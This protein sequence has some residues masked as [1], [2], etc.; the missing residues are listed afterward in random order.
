MNTLEHIVKFFIYKSII[1]VTL[2][3]SVL[4]MNSVFA[5][6]ELPATTDAPVEVVATVAPATTSPE[7]TNAALEVLKER[8]EQIKETFE[9]SDIEKEEAVAQSDL[10][11]VQLEKKTLE[12]INSE[13][14]TEVLQLQQQIAE[15]ESLKT[16]L[17]LAEQKNSES[18][19]KVAEL[20]NAQKEL[21]KELEIRNLLLTKNQEDID[22]L[23]QE[24]ALKEYALEQ[25]LELQ[26][27]LQEKTKEENSK[28]VWIFLMTT[29]FFLIIYIIRIVVAKKIS[30][31]KLT[32][33]K[34]AHKFA[35]FD[36]ISFLGY[37]GFLVWFL[38]YLKPEMVVYL[39]FLVG[40]IVIVVQEYIFSVVSSIF[41]IQTYQ[42]GAR[43]RFDGEE[44]IIEGMNLLKISIRTIDNIGTNMQELR[45][46]PNSQ[47]M[48]KEVTILPRGEIEKTSFRVVLPNDLSINQPVFI[49]NVEEEI[50]QKNITVKSV[51]E[52]TDKEY[53]YE[54]D[55]SFMNTGQ[56]VIE[57]FWYETR[58]K[59]NRIKRKILA[60]LEKFKKNSKQSISPA[61][62]GDEKEEIQG[63]E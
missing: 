32:A 62:K 16:S 25:N 37:L 19:A 45:I 28:K 34:Y 6:D 49:K 38:F 58:E 17:S 9:S 31:N 2:L 7:V 61:E 42:V 48:K 12:E 13:I 39:L 5:E 3:V 24:E 27:A 52:I 22:L 63:E 50:L 56:P 53:F 57:I 41:I 10:E 23:E 40:A 11:I 51:N 59:S 60:E 35:A 47:F 46:I 18:E 44:G 14:E 8:Q 55:F 33:K 21:Q 43:I 1:S 30:E 29:L 26:K 36:I 15:Q 54:I 4:F 20:E